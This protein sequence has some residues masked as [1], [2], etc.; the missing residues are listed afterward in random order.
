MPLRQPALP[1]MRTRI[2]SGMVIDAGTTM[3]PAGRT[4]RW[5]AMGTGESASRAGRDT[6]TG[7]AN[8]TEAE[9]RLRHE[10]QQLRHAM[11]T[12]AVIDQARGMIMALVPCSSEAA[13]QLLVG[14]SQHCNVKLRDLAGALVATTAGRPL[15]PGLQQ[16]LCH[17]FRDHALGPARHRPG[18]IR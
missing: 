6:G 4:G 15:P 14:I 7:Y 3:T 13:W 16:R 12:R 1:G 17:A 5:C 11:E 10:N 18:R 8:G 9:E 2:R